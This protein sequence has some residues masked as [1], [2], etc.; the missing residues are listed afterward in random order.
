MDIDKIYNG[1]SENYDIDLDFLDDI[2][3]TLDFRI[4][5][6]RYHFNNINNYISSDA[7]TNIDYIYYECE[8]LIINIRSTLDNLL[9]LINVVYE[10]GFNDININIKN[11]IRHKNFTNALRD[12]FLLHTHPKNHFW[13]FI[14]TTRN[15]IV[16][17]V[18]IKTELPIVIDEV[19]DRGEF[20]QKVVFINKNGDKENLIQF[21]K[22]CI[23]LIEEL[24]DS[25]LY[26][27]EKGLR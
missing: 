18:C 27:L 1:V 8:N 15:E 7:T 17:E 25:S 14:Y 16:H 22:Q 19:L 26:A 12:V 6:N 11:M 10:M 13:H 4:N 9:Q 21:L 24:V 5:K 20:V 3:T 23:K 2:L